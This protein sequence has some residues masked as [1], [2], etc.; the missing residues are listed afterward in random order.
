MQTVTLDLNGQLQGIG[1]LLFVILC[2][3]IAIY[4]KILKEK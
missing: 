1:I 4:F 2:W 3:V